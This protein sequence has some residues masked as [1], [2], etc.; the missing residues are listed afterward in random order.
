MKRKIF[1][2]FTLLVSVLVL[3]AQTDVFKADANVVSVKNPMAFKSVKKQKAA[4]SRASLEA[5]ER[6]MGYYTGDDI[7]DDDYA[8]GMQSRGSYKAGSD[9]SEKVTARF[10]G[11]QIVKVRFALWESVG[12]SNVSVY[13]AVGTAAP[14]LITTEP[15]AETVVGWNEVALSEP[16]TI[17]EG[18]RYVIAYDFRQKINSW[19]LAVDAMVNPGGAETGGFIVYGDLGKGEGWYSMGLGTGNLMVQAVVRG[20]DFSDDDISLGTVATYGLYC[21]KGGKMEFLFSIKNNGNKI[22]ESYDVKVKLDNKDI[23]A[24]LNLPALTGVFQTVRGSLLLPQ[25]ATTGAHVL[26]IA[27]DKI[28]GQ[29]P[30][31]YTEDDVISVEF[32]AYNKCFARSMQLV[33]QFTSTYC[34][35][36]P[37][38][39]DALGALASAREDIAWVS[40]H[41]DMGA[42]AI[43]DYTIPESS[44]IRAFSCTGFPT[45]SFNRMSL[46]DGDLA[47]GISAGP[48][49]IE[50]FVSSLSE[51]MDL[52]NAMYY[53]AFTTVDIATDYDKD[54][55]KLNIKVTGEKSAEDFSVFVGDD[56][57]LTVY[58]TED[59]LVSKQYNQGLWIA[60]YTHNNVLRSIVS[61]A[62]G[63]AVNWTGENFENSYDVAVGDGWNIDNMHVVA[64]ISRPIVYKEATGKFST[65]IDNAW[66]INTNKVK[67]T[68]VYT[69]DISGTAVGADGVR[70]VARFSVDGQRLEQPVKGI[71]IVKLSDGR[72]VKVVVK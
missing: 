53:P 65:K 40:V 6:L 47:I 55:G 13:K 1:S 71:N 42:T 17:E 72:T 51:A 69:S 36:C 26:T 11:G 58:L 44:L 10:V 37:L 21:Q 59:G 24:E 39:N 62:L 9:F 4:P 22:P 49:Q 38:G 70:E 5:G 27:I 18:V 57:V 3:N 60:E 25:D 2:L 43:D 31:D 45:A 7:G 20:G 67:V 35:Y 46:G 30:V 34:T 28:N 8:L 68:D 29:T 33:E 48:T 32:N 54:S 52:L 23:D 19:P 12:E 41:G 14:E 64:F 50:S 63:D 16:V 61:A 56:A 15:V 66:V